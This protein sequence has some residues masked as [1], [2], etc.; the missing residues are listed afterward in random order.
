LLSSER[1]LFVIGWAGLL[2][3]DFQF[4]LHVGGEVVDAEAFFEVVE[5]GHQG[6]ANHRDDL[7]LEGVD[8]RAE[9]HVAHFDVHDLH[10]FDEGLQDVDFEEVQGQ[11]FDCCHEHI[12]GLGLLVE[13][14]HEGANGHHD[15][16][17]YIGREGVAAGA[18]EV[19]LVQLPLAEDAQ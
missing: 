12:C 14:L 4:V 7:V 17:G 15:G 9:T 6:L 5:E 8:H 1:E 2:V 18:D 3:R 11:L 16:F 13:E 19:E 10:H